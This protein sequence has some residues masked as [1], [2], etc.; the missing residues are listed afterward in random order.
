MSNVG[1]TSFTFTWYDPDQ[2]QC[3]MYLKLANDTLAGVDQFWQ[4]L[5]DGSRREVGYDK[6]IFTR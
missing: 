6:L 2:N 4:I 5:V 3:F 1:D